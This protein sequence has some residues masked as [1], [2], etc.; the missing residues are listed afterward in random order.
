MM[1]T[2]ET[3]KRDAQQSVEDLRKRGF[4]PA[5]FYGPKQE[6]TPIM[7]DARRLASLWKQAG[8]TTIIKLEGAG[9]G[10]ETLIKDVQIHPVT[11][12]ILHA[13][14]Y[15]L[16]KGKKIEIAVPLEFVG[17]AP[18]EKQGHI[19]SKA[20]HEI[21]IEVA[22]AEL[23]HSLTVDLSILAHPGDHITASQITLPPSAVLKTGADEIVASVTEHHEE[24]V[25]QE[26]VDAPVVV[27]E[28]ET[29]A[30]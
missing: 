23:P 15:A 1:M 30:S 9:D 6:A 13:D 17:E 28:T 11:S 24:V 26:P 19:I 5:V 4:A 18:A 25:Q 10:V 14:F 8:E 21:E 22:P 16:E 12:M 29:K 20:L 7:V 27:S 2:L 3:Q